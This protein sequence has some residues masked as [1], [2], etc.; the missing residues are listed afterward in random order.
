MNNRKGQKIHRSALKRLAKIRKRSKRKGILAHYTYLA[1]FLST[2][3]SE[4]T[5]QDISLYR[6]SHYPYI[7]DDFKPQIFQDSNPNSPESLEVPSKDAPKDIILAYTSWFT[8]S[9]YTTEQA[10]IDE[11][12]RS[13]N[14]RLQKAKPNKR[15]KVKSD[16]IRGKGEYI[17]KIDYSKADGLVGPADDGIHK[18]V[19]IYDGVDI[20]R[21]VDKDY[22]PIKISSYDAT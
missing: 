7:A 15:D 9:H 12:N 14:K 3:E 6:W 17:I 18:E 16:W 2:I 4:Y 5:C 8:I 13:L 11:W 1:P 21:L 19:F 10:A 20:A 22:T